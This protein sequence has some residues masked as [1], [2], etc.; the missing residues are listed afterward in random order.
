MQH[1][2][3]TLQWAFNARI[4]G[5]FPLFDDFIEALVSHRFICRE[6]DYRSCG[7]EYS[8]N[9]VLPYF[10]RSI[11]D[12]IIWNLRIVVL[13]QSIIILKIGKIVI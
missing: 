5:W 6:V 2:F 9:I 11:T 4:S 3:F 7:I 12:D 10:K 1:T 8:F 13:Q